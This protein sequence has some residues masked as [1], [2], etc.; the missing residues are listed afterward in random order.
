M[1]KFNSR[2]DTIASTSLKFNQKCI[3]IRNIKNSSYRK[4][5]E[6]ADMSEINTNMYKLGELTYAT[7]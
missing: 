1:V 3:K 4:P 5:N 2:S 7:Y 6:K